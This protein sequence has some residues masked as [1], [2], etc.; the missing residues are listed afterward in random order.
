MSWRWTQWI[1]LFWGV[2]I[3]LTSLFQSET[4]KKVIL[5]HR[6]KKLKLPQP[7]DPVPS[8]WMLFDIIFLRAIRMLLTEPIVAYFSIYTAFIFAVLFGFFSCFPYVFSHVYGF[9]TGEAGL[10]FIAIGVGCLLA[11]AA[12]VEIDRRTYVRQALQRINN[13]DSRPLPSEERLYPAMVGCFLVPMGLFWFAWTARPSVHW[14]VPVLALIPFGC[15]NLMVFDSGQFSS[16]HHSTFS[17]NV[18]PAIMYLTDVYGPLNGASASAANSFLR[19][20]AGAAFPLFTVQMFQALG[21]AWAG[22]LL[23]FVAIAL[24]PIPWVFYKYGPT[25]R[26]RSSFETS[27]A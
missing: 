2:P 21:V 6:A 13:G 16:P 15:G 22:S 3:Y 25:L 9:N 5:R 17:F 27:K 11:T 12:F 23:G 10:V 19:Y 4:Y 8:A 20:I 1:I 26:A 14:I 18:L 24:I 7:S